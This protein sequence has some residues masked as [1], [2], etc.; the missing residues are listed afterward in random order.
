MTAELG[1]FVAFMSAG[2]KKAVDGW[3]REVLA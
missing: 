1:G 2:A 3:L